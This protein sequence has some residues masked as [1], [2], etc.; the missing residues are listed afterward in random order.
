MTPKAITTLVVNNVLD[1]IN[2][3]G[4]LLKVVLIFR[5]FARTRKDPL[6]PNPNNAKLII[7]N[8]K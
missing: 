4:P 1:T 5:L 8:A 3:S 6:A 2:N 7:K